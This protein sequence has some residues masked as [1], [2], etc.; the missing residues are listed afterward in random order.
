MGPHDHASYY[1]GPSLPYAIDLLHWLM[2]NESWTVEEKQRLNQVEREL[3]GGLIGATEKEQIFTVEGRKKM[4]HASSW[5]IPFAGLAMLG[6]LDTC[7]GVKADGT[8]M[9]KF[10]AVRETTSE[11]SSPMDGL[12]HA[13]ARENGFRRPDVFLKESR[14]NSDVLFQQAEHQQESAGAQ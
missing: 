8:A 9:L 14:S 2:K 5:E 6:F 7:N 1:W 11:P 12:G 10:W 4:A 13:H 3:A